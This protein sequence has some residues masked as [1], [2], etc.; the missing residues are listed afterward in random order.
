MKCRACN[1]SVEQGEVTQHYQDSFH[2]ENLRRKGMGIGPIAFDEWKQQQPAAQPEEAKTAK[3]IDASAVFLHAMQ[4][5][6]CFYCEANIPTMAT[7]YAS[8]ERFLAHLETHG[9]KLLMPHCIH[10]TPGLMEYLEKKISYCVCTFCNKRFPNITKLRMHMQSMWHMRYMNSDEYDDYYTYPERPLAY[11]TED[12]A[13]LLLPSGRVAGHR[14]YAK[15]YAQT[16]REEEYYKNLDPIKVKFEKQQMA[17][18]EQVAASKGE[19]IEIEKHQER[20]SRNHLRVS[21]SANNQSH[22]RD[23]WMQ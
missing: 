13:E 22:F 6:E 11:I 14:K 5:G 19:L 3:L 10:D 9:F 20:M 4:K 12:G 15:Y 7:P 8:D 23:D 1:V 18:K 2:T 17:R 16:L 21:K